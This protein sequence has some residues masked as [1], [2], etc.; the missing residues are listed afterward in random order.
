MISFSKEQLQEGISLP[1]SKIKIS[2]KEL[3]D[4]YDIEEDRS[5][6]VLKETQTSDGEEKS[7]FEIYTEQ[8]DEKQEKEKK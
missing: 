7:E 1:E 5:S 2:R 4:I 8:Y 3:E 6:E